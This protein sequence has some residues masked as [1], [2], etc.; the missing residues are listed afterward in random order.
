MAGNFWIGLRPTGYLNELKFDKARKEINIALTNGANNPVTLRNAARVFHVLG[1]SAEAT[2]LAKKAVE[3]DPV[4]TRSW[5]YLISNYLLD[6]NYSEALKAIEQAPDTRN[7]LHYYKVICLLKLNRF[8]EAG[9]LIQDQNI[10]RGF[11]QVLLN[12]FKGVKDDSL[13]KKLEIEFG[14][15]PE[16]GLWLAQL[17]ANSGNPDKAMMYINKA[18]AAKNYD[19]TLAFNPLYSPLRKDPRFTK[20]F[21]KMNYPKYKCQSEK[22]YLSLF[23]SSNTTS[24]LVS[25]GWTSLLLLFPQR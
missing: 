9:K 17:F 18:V 5:F 25:L 12:S 4:Q 19:F 2:A 7:V 22:I 14:D 20:F 11:F 24:A 1:R 13:L 10:A 21:E 8:S 6:G 23:P 16:N 3:L 15:K